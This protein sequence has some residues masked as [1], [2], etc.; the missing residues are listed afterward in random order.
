MAGGHKGV[1]EARF[2]LI[3]WDALWYVARVFGKGAEKYAERN[4]ERGLKYGAVAGARDRHNALFA[5]GQDF[6]EESG[7]PH[8]AHSAWHALVLLALWLR[9]DLEDDRSGREAVTEMTAEVTNPEDI[10]AAR[11]EAQHIPEFGLAAWPRIISA[12]AVGNSNDDA[13]LEPEVE[14]RGYEYSRSSDA[15]ILR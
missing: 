2:D 14:A 9:G 5:A 6:D 4:W 3:P 11:Q 15:W 10:E 13:Y 8:L 12:S 7:L 1:K